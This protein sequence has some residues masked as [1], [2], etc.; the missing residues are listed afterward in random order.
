[1][2]KTATDT[3]IDLDLIK[4][5]EI[6]D[7]FSFHCV[8]MIK[9]PFSLC[10][11]TLIDESKIG[12]NFMA[13]KA[14]KSE[15][16]PNWETPKIRQR[17]RRNENSEKLT[18]TVTNKTPITRSKCVFW[19][20]FGYWHFACISHVSSPAD[21]LDSSSDWPVPQYC[22][23]PF[24][25]FSFAKPLL[26]PEIAIYRTLNQHR[27][28][29]VIFLPRTS[30]WWS[31]SVSVSGEIQVPCCAFRLLHFFHTRIGSFS[32]ITSSI[33]DPISGSIMF[34]NSSFLV[35][36]VSSQFQ[37]FPKKSTETKNVSIISRKQ[38][39][40]YEQKHNINICC[41]NERKMSHLLEEIK[42]HLGCLIR[43]Q[44][45]HDGNA[46]FSWNIGYSIM[47]CA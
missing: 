25:L 34:T 36:F 41:S 2:I 11:L 9:R 28:F 19:C 24:T 16:N 35:V 15:R 10:A 33:A 46:A 37:I 40:R 27:F 39:F 22:F 1:M 42:S 6:N 7:L 23:H 45:E 44:Y 3:K 32:C 17:K 29:M 26:L 12:V 47:M 31:A 30:V 20:Y 18:R 14:A 43:K 38:D 21:T 13:K 8:A 4:P 5:I